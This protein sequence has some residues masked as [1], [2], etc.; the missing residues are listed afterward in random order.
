MRLDSN[1]VNTFNL[2]HLGIVAGTCRELRIAERIDDLIANKDPRRV[3]SCGQ[4]VVAMIINGLGFVGRTLYMT[5]EF[6]AN[7]PV[8]RLFDK[9]ITAEDLNDNALGKALDEIARFGPTDLF[10]RT[11]FGIALEHKLMGTSA[12]L[13]STT[14][15]MEGEYESQPVE[16]SSTTSSDNSSAVIERMALTSENGMTEGV[17]KTD[18]QWAD[19]KIVHGFAK[20][21]PDL[22]QFI[23]QMAVTGPAELPFWHE[24][25]DGNISDKKSFHD[26]IKKV[27]EFK[28]ALKDGPEFKWIADSALYSADKLLQLKNVLWISR[29]PETITEAK[30]LTKMSHDKIEWKKAQNGYKYSSYESNYGN[31]K[32]RWLLVHSEQAYKREVKTFERNLVKQEESLK[33]QLWHLGNQ[34]FD[35]Q[36]SAHK[37]FKAI[38][39]K[40]FVLQE[41]YQK[42]FKYAEKG[43]PAAGVTPIDSVWKVTAC[44][45]KNEK[46][47]QEVLNTKGRFILATNDL[48]SSKTTDEQILTEYKEQQSVE[49]GFRFFKDPWFMV[50]KVFLKSPKRI[51]ALGMVMTLC[52]LV[53]NYAQYTLRAQLQVKKETIPNQLGKQIDKPTMRWVFQMF[54][55]IS[56]VKIWDDTRQTTIEIVSNLNK[57]TRKILACLGS[58]TRAIYGIP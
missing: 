33:K 20:Q 2:D 4:A 28:K 42:H 9:D 11:S 24:T 27:Q 29:V 21:R 36:K 14:I 40:L 32:Q 38:T 8:Q 53:Y 58:V 15:A 10:A 35:S 23:L 1:S 39:T 49:R 30:N 3:V 47:I 43:R 51:S 55:G 18:S 52:L 7:K 16:T 13:D 25:L 44:V 37:A 12:H 41:T 17:L 54:S 5:P 46:A 6:F 26:T 50:D 22:K 34:E 57:W 19:I 31:I 56:I 45:S 48:D